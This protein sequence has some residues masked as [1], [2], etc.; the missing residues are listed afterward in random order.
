MHDTQNY[1]ALI[2]KYK[3]YFRK[4]KKLR[5]CQSRIQLS[6]IKKED[7]DRF[8]SIKFRYLYI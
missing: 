5:M 2:R 1:F 3:T 8:Y 4:F 7:I 6:H